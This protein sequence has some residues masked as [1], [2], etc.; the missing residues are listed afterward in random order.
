MSE[1][2]YDNSKAKVGDLSLSKNDVNLRIMHDSDYQVC[3]R[4]DAYQ[5]IDEVFNGRKM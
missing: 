2:C 4:F 1:I 5:E 3:Q